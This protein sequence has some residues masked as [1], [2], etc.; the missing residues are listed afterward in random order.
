[1]L[2]VGT[3]FGDLSCS[4]QP[5][6]KQGTNKSST[7][8]MPKSPKGNP[9]WWSVPSAVVLE[10]VCVSLGLCNLSQ[11]NTVRLRI[12]AKSIMVKAAI[13][14]FWAADGHGNSIRLQK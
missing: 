3:Y 7:E 1:M 6:R 11:T 2:F 5:L 9:L 4:G 8:H 14:K 12:K 13:P 10:V